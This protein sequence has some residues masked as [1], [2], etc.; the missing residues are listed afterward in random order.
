MFAACALGCFITSL[1]LLT[2]KELYESSNI[3]DTTDQQHVEE[4]TVQ[5][6][7]M[8]VP[9]DKGS[10]V[11]E[12][13]SSVLNRIPVRV[14]KFFQCFCPILNTMGLFH[15]KDSSNQVQCLDGIRLFDSLWVILSH[16]LGYLL[17][18]L[19]NTIET[20]NSVDQIAFQIII[21]GFYSV[22][23]FFALSGF[24]QAWQFLKQKGELGFFS[25]IFHRLVRLFPIYAVVVGFETVLFHLLGSGPLWPVDGRKCTGY[26]WT[27]LIFVNNFLYSEHQ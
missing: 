15:V 12:F 4:G 20:A 3:K 17:P 18:V 22:D 23:I 1:N 24:L 21:N 13:L 7:Q 26:W 11:V 19:G 6:F 2:G 25:T 14:Q 27:N 10:I 16:T 5:N 9:E 8:E